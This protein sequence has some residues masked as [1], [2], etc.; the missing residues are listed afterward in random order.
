[1]VSSEQTPCCCPAVTEVPRGL[2]NS[3]VTL[4]GWHGGPH[5]PCGLSCAPQWGPAQ[6]WGT[7]QVWSQESCQPHSGPVCVPSRGCSA[8]LA[9]PA[10]LQQLHPRISQAQARAGGTH[11]MES[12]RWGGTEAAK[13]FQGQK[14]SKRIPKCWEVSPADLSLQQCWEF[15]NPKTSW[16]E[17]IS[18]LYCRDKWAPSASPLL[19]GANGLLRLQVATCAKVTW[20]LW[21]GGD[22]AF[23]TEGWAWSGFPSLVPPG[24]VGEEP[25]THRAHTRS[26]G[27]G[28]CPAAFQDDP[29]L[30][31]EVGI[32][33]Q[34]TG[35]PWSSHQSCPQH[36]DFG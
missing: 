13:H 3:G 34:G 32:F 35:T 33:S 24:S 23:P 2:G 17:E 29:V 19:P 16:G 14:S 7:A 15:M 30:M 5:P 12:W 31:Q 25:S 4:G 18:D 26:Q 28:K 1:M 6:S 11:S 20:W 21:K 22:E 10:G 27:M 36:W 8:V 9:L